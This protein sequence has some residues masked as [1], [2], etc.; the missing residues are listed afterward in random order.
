MD[1]RRV[2]PGAQEAY[3]VMVMAPEALRTICRIT[4]YPLF[5]VDDQGS[6]VMANIRACDLLGY[7]E[8]ELIGQ[9][10]EVLVPETLRVAHRGQR[11]AYLGMAEIRHV[12]EGL[13][14]DARRRDGSEIPV[15]VTLVP[16]DTV[17]GRAVIASVIDLRQRKDLESQL[18]DERDFSEAIIDS[19]PGLF[20]LLNREGRFLRWNRNVELVTGANADEL[21][22][23]PAW[24]LFDDQDAERIREA[25]E[26][27]FREG[28]CEIDAELNTRDGVSIPYHFTGRRVELGGQECLTGAGIDISNQKAL[29]ARLRYQASHDSL[30]GLVNRNYF[31]EL[32]RQEFA[33]A[34]R[35]ETPF[36]V[37]MMDIDHFKK[38]NDHFGHLT[39][40]QVLRRFAE[41]QQARTRTSDILARWGGEEFALLLPETDLAGGASLAEAVRARVA[42]TPMPGPG[43]I[44]VSLAVTA[45][46]DGESV[47]ELLKRLDEALYA[48][49]DSGRNRVVVC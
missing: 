6:I 43:R 40:D 47:H 12:R 30:T 25:I 44:T 3:G 32:L 18:R 1:M 34:K 49:K 38:V 10:I 8:D 28:G 4:P 45:H 16:V 2:P 7:P 17:Q 31:E 11:D 39:G 20:Y 42:E 29:E 36:S 46:R 23:L 22:R 27:V 14:V 24:S 26:A 13:D 35:S 9:P 48:A 37:V 21:A 41:S 15:E 19:L 33:R 5:L